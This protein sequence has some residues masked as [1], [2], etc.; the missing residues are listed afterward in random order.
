MHFFDLLFAHVQLLLCMDLHGKGDPSSLGPP[1][2]TPVTHHTVL[3]LSVCL[4]ACLI[5][6]AACLS[7]CL[8]ACPPACLS[9][10]SVCLPIRLCF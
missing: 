10:W 3:C 2:L 6:V 7:A 9:A 4:L 1:Y 8:S 5:H